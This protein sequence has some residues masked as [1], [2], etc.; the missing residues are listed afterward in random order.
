MSFV[1]IYHGSLPDM[2]DM[3]KLPLLDV[4]DEE[5]KV[6]ELKFSSTRIAGGQFSVS[7]GQKVSHYL[8]TFGP[9]PEAAKGFRLRANGKP[10]VDL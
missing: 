10:I 9:I 8:R 4:V 6:Y 7:E 5:G 3:M 2:W 1:Q